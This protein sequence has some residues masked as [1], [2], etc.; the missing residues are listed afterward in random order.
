MFEWIYNNLATIII[1][2]CLIGI[3]TLIIVK[4]I[5]DKRAGKS[6]CSCGCGNCSMNEICHKK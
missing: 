1:C 2:G 5:K 6:S 4:M 3:V